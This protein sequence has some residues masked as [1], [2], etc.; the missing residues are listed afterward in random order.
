MNIKKSLQVFLANSTTPIENLWIK[1]PFHCFKC[2]KA[3]INSLSPEAETWR[4]EKIK[5]P[6][7]RIL[8]FVGTG[9]WTS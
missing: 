8:A 4:G 3:I 1:T 5:G 9:A 6:F 7:G 2:H